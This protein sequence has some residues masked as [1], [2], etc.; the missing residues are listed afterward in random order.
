MTRQISFTRLEQAVAPGFRE[1]MD[2]A[3]STEDV[4]KFFAEMASTLLSDALGK[5]GAVRFEDVVLAPDVPNGYTISEAI[6]EV[7]A[8]RETW[9]GSDLSRIVATL[10]RSAVHRYAHLDKNPLKTEAKIFHHKQG[11]R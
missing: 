4:R 7:P 10:A 2:R 3:E 8:F 6:L 11:K 9:E 1:R 5:P